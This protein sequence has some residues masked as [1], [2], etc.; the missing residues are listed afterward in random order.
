MRSSSN[1]FLILALDGGGMRGLYAASLLRGLEN[2]F[3]RKRGEPPN[4][5]L[6]VGAGFDLVVGTSTGALLAAGIVAGVP[7]ERIRDLFWE[8]GP[9][10]FS[11]PVPAEGRLVG[12][13]KKGWLLR[14]A[15]RPAAHAPALRRALEELLRNETFADVYKR[16]RIGLCISATD[17]LTSSPRVFKTPHVPDKDLD[18]DMMLRDACMASS[19]APVYLPIASVESSTGEHQ[20]YSDGGLWANNPI[21]VGLIEGLTMAAPERP[22]VVLSVGT[23][24]PLSGTTKPK[25]LCVGFWHWA[26]DVRLLQLAMNSQ[27]LGAQHAAELLAASL[28]KAGRR[29]T[30]LRCAES[31]PSAEEAPLL[32]LDSASSKALDHMARLGRQDAISTYGWT[33]TDSSRGKLLKLIFGKMP[34]ISTADHKQGDQK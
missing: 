32:Q 13:W 11:R 26:S 34:T 10:I 31:K 4:R 17:V 21:V 25:K 14:H 29:V 16:R 22:I 30:V 5:P 23:C 12:L 19:A 7:L 24:P 6:D 2:R 9:K 1:P 27:S 33:Q 20:Y 15:F 18:N 8:W 28:S 3:G